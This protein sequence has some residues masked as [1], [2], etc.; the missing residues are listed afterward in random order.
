MNVQE[1]A[2]FDFTEGVSPVHSDRLSK[3]VIEISTETGTS[4]L[5]KRVICPFV[6]L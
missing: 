2:L 3:E 1:R 5:S 4:H 6:G